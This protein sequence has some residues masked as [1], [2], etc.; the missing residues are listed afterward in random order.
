MSLVLGAL[1]GCLGESRDTAN[2]AVSNAV[3]YQGPTCSCCDRYGS[4]LDRHLITSLET[5]ETNDLSGVK[6]EHGVH[7]DLWSC[8]TVD[9]DGFIVEGHVP[10]G[11]IEEA[12]D[13]RGTIDGI[14][15]PGMPVGS[16]GMGGVQLRSWEIFAIDS[17][18]SYTHHT[19]R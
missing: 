8:H 18:G 14:A 10:V 5:V 6:R 9:L 4:Y 2:L 13:S 1:A 16:P 15:L 11:V 17:D 19:D 12:L 7:P 3:Q